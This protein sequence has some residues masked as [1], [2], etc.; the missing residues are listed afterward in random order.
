MELG[1][2][3]AL[4]LGVGVS[5]LL[6]TSRK[7]ASRGK[8]KHSDSRQSFDKSSV[9]TKWSEIE[10]TFNLAGPSNFK[11]A[12]MEADKLVDYVLKGIGVRG[13]SMGDRLKNA[14]NKFKNYDDYNNL[15]FAHKVRNNI[16]HEVSHEVNSA[17]AKRAI[18]YFKKALKDLGVL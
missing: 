5:L 10:S 14:R 13:E 9:G 6:V 18:E 12:I 3:L 1:V 2:V 4:A 11:A 16:A 8:L 7:P 17:E 15:W